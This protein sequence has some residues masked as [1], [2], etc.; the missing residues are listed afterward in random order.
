MIT[1][2]DSEWSREHIEDIAL[3]FKDAVYL[4]SFYSEYV[5]T[6]DDLIILDTGYEIWTAALLY[7]SVFNGIDY[8][9]YCK[10]YYDIYIKAVENLKKDLSR[11]KFL[12][13]K[14]LYNIPEILRNAVDAL[15]YVLGIE[16]T[17]ELAEEMR[18]DGVYDEWRSEITA[19][20]K[21]LSVHIKEDL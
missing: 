9:I 7:D 3:F 18:K 6:E 5:Q 21:R 12:S 4:N 14:P 20:Q 13:F 2:F 15:D 8:S 1:P 11:K 10:G 16:N 17:S 19:L